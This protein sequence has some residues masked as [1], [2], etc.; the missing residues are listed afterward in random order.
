MIKKN[1]YEGC[2]I[3]ATLI[4]LGRWDLGIVKDVTFAFSGAEGVDK[5]VFVNQAHDKFC[6]SF[7]S[8]GTTGMGQNQYD[9]YDMNKKRHNGKPCYKLVKVFKDEKEVVEYLETEENQ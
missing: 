7:Y 1:K 6:C 2:G 9:F 5:L 3:S 4:G 8:G